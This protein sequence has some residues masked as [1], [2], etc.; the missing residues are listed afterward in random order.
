MK[1]PQPEA[2]LEILL[3]YL[4]CPVD[5]AGPL[6]TVRDDARQVVA[7]RSSWGEYPVVNNVPCMIPGHVQGLGRNV[8]LW[9]KHQDEMWRDFEEGEEDVFSGKNE[10]TD[11]IGEIIDQREDGLFLDV[12]CGALPL[13]PY[14]AA[15]SGHVHWIGI[16][17]FLGDAV[18]EFPFAQALG[19]Y[20][21]FRPNVFDGVLYAST[22]YH[23]MEPRQSLERTRRALRPHG[24]LYIWYEP[25]RSKLRYIF[26]KTRRAL[27]WPCRYSRFHH[28]AFTHGSLRSLL[29][30]TGFTVEEVILLC[31]RCPAYGKCKAPGE[32]LAIAR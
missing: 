9:Q 21:P 24:R 10:T 22:I 29:Q 8:A 30:R 12:G 1:S 18:R 14:M 3:Q 31:A 26:W 32:F 4:A 2:F 5:A 23:Q 6:A 11:Y 13:P 28:W 7:L 15:S 16:D 25:P 27:G 20:L 19:E 17:P